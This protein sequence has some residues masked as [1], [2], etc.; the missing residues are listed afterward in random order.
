MID[1]RPDS[2]TRIQPLLRWIGGKQ[3]LLRRLVSFVPADYKKRCYREPF[4]GAGSMFLALRPER[5]HLADANQHLIRCYEAVRDSLNRVSAYLR[6]HAAKDCPDHYY[7]VR[8]DYN[9]RPA[10][11]AQAAR[12]LY[13]NR[14]CF[15]GVFRV[16]MRGKFNVPYG[17]KDH[18]VFPDREDLALVSQALAQA[19]LAAVDY[20][21]SLA[22]AEPGDFLYLDPPYPPLNGT[23]YFTHYTKDRF[24][25][26]DQ[27]ALAESVCE[28]DDQG[29][30]FMMSNADTRMIR[31][32][33]RNFHI[34]RLPVTRYVTCKA[35]KHRVREL[36]ITNY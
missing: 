5:A 10:S 16:N 6:D 24:D 33:Y 4:L 21:D 7:T 11:V 28:L 29:C 1:D 17:Y 13:L 23:S 36:V 14:T 31:R 9:R 32:L 26:D 27:R 15:N 34:T 8:E 19:E 2:P 25:D 35:T 12:F 22:D 3:H 20:Q 30:L 18:P